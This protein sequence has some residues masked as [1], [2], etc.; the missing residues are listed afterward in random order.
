MITLG[1]KIENIF[2]KFGE[3]EIRNFSLAWKDPY[4]PLSNNTKGGFIMKVHLNILS[5]EKM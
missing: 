2:Q 3:A 1:I 4:F 5:V